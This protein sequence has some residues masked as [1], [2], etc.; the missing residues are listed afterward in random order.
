MGK[1]AN[2]VELALIT[3]GTSSCGSAWERPSGTL[4]VRSMGKALALVR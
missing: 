1:D 3:T 2:T 4:R